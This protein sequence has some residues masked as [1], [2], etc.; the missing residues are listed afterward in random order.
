MKYTIAFLFL[1]LSSISHGQPIAQT[2]ERISWF[3]MDMNQ[4]Y[5][6]NFNIDFDQN[7]KLS[8]GQPFQ[9]IDSVSGYGPIIVYSFLDMTC[10]DK[11][12]VAE[13]ILFNPEPEDLAHDKSVGM[14][15]VEECVLQVYVEPKYAFDVSIFRLPSWSEKKH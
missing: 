14:E 7:Y 11:A 15:L 3:D 5:V 2:G 9:L 13:L 8:E 1:I 10:Q 12:R 4:K 6:L